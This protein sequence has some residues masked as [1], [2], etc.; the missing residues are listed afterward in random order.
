MRLFEIQ[1]EHCN[2]WSVII[3]QPLT[4]EQH[5]LTSVVPYKLNMVVQVS[6]LKT[7]NRPPHQPHHYSGP[8]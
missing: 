6:L 3:Y 2:R 7:V 8:A 4:Q 5:V 1:N